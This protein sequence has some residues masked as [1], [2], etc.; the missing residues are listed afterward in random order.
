MGQ[1]EAYCNCPM[2]LGLETN[3]RV[4]LTWWQS[5]DKLKLSQGPGQWPH[6][7]KIWRGHTG[8]NKKIWAPCRILIS[9]AVRGNRKQEFYIERTML[10]KIV[11]FKGTIRYFYNTSVVF[12]EGIRHHFGTFFSCQCPV[13]GTV[14]WKLTGV[15]SGINRKLMICH[16][17]DGYS[18]FH[19]KDLRSLKSKKMISALTGTLL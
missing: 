1:P 18:F 11:A 9:S 15:L 5:A 4:F 16:C 14:Q 7:T 19:L 8:N 6:T 12:I 13:K 17:S 3:L 10:I 2:V